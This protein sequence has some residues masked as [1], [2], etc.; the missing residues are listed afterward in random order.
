MSKKKK[1]YIIELTDLSGVGE[2]TAAQMMENGIE[3]VEEL[4]TMRPERLS[5]IIGCSVKNAK[6]YVNAATEVIRGRAIEV[7]TA[8]EIFKIRSERVQRIKTGSKA[9]DDILGGGVQTDAITGVAGELSVGKSQLAFQLEVNSVLDLNREIAHLE[10]EPQT[11]NA[12]RIIEMTKGRVNFSDIADKF[13]I[14]P[15]TS[16]TNPYQQFNAYEEV[17]KMVEGGI[18][19]GL[20]VIDSFTAKFRPFFHGREMLP[21]RGGELARHIGYL[22]A[23]ASKHNMAIFMTCQVMGV[24][25][26]M[27]Q[28]G[29]IKKFGGRKEIWGGEY[30]KHSVTYWLYLQEIKKDRYQAT[31]FD[32]PDMPRAEAE[33]IITTQG[34]RDVS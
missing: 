31:L 7:L 9:L 1:G 11:F 32:A 34:I 2:K 21:D 15:H 24:P 14:V 3:T 12:K 6:K 22:E 5:Q 16:I 18:D 26:Q 8:K 17:N 33:Y 20:L 29:V 30:F 25:D 23:M 28:L 4:A 27:S 13:H 19:I 10:T